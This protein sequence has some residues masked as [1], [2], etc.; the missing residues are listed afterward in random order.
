MGFYPIN[1]PSAFLFPWG[2][3]NFAHYISIFEA[4][5]KTQTT[6]K[7]ISDKGK[8]GTEGKQ[9]SLPGIIGDF[10]LTNEIKN[11][12]KQTHNDFFSPTRVNQEVSAVCWRGRTDGGAN[13]LVGHQ[14]TYSEESP[15]SRQCTDL[16]YCLILLFKRRRILARLAYF[17]ISFPSSDSIPPCV[18]KN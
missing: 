1:F 9:T 16:I 5:T 12:E 15:V 3:G 8:G 7:Q 2:G 4:V 6:R 17:I 13:S 18:S 14:M 11:Q 10:N